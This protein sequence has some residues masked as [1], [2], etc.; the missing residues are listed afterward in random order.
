[1]K[2]LIV[3]A[4][5][6]VALPIL[7]ALIGLTLPRRHTATRAVVVQQP[8]S[9]VF[10]V[11]SNFADAPQWRSGVTA[12]ELLPARNGLRGFREKTRHGWISYLVEEETPPTRMVTRIAD[13][14]LPF[15]GSWTYQLEPV[16]NGCRVRITENGEVKNPLFRFLARFVFG[17]A[18]TLEAYLSDLA[19]RFGE[20][21]AISS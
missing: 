6:L 19:R 14:T 7:A 2:W 5:I 17:Y 12:V 8:A 1:M 9:T 4:A 10:A 16:E 18:G 21:P 20:A 15:G 3:V 13:E 11:I